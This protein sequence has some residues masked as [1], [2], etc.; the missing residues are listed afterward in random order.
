MVCDR[1]IFPEKEGELHRCIGHGRNIKGKKWNEEFELT[2][3]EYRKCI[4]V[5]DGMAECWMIPIS[6]K[7]RKG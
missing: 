3:E 6:E 2:E 4:W 7:K 5:E 1:L